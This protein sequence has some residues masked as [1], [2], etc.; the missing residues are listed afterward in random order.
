MSQTLRQDIYEMHTPG[1]QA[2]QAESNRV[3]KCIPPEVQYACLYWVQH[4]QRSGSRVYY[5]EAYRFLQAH[6]LHWP[7]ALGWIGK[8]SEGIQAILTLEAQISV[9]FYYY[10]GE[11]R[12]IDA[13]WF[14]LYNRLVI[15]QVPLQLYCSALVFTPANSVVRRQFEDCIP[16]WIQQK[17]KTQ[18]YWSA[19]M[20]TLEGHTSRVLSVA[21]S[22]DGKQIVSGS[23]DNTA[24]LWDATTGASLQ[25]LK[26][27]IQDITSVAFSADGK[28]VVSGSRDKTARL[29]GAATGLLKQIF[30]GHTQD[31]WSVAFS[32]DSKQLVSGSHDNTVRI[33]DTAKGALLRTLEGYI[34][35]VRSVA[36]SPDGKQVVSASRDK[37]IRL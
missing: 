18:A 23:G 4:L 14:V 19:D 16:G 22:P 1:N 13:K 31:I 34:C 25:I 2:T 27:H 5:E 37:T 8:T 11:F 28:Q 20:Q 29:W 17:L 26:G 21:F 32:P 33:W 15:E 3:Q 6:L 7:E 24:R 10:F 35:W 9:S 12:L 30:E 36:F